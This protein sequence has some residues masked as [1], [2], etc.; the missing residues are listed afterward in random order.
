MI[1]LDLDERW[2]RNAAV[3]G[4]RVRR[5][6]PR[7]GPVRMVGIDGPSG[8]GKSEF[9]EA[10]VDSLR[11]RGETVALVPTDDFATWETPVGW[12]PRLEAGVLEPL[13]EGAPGSYRRMEWPDGRPALGG[14]VTV[15]VPTVLVVEGVSATRRAVASRLSLAIWVELTGAPTRLNRSVARDGAWSR[16]ALRRWQ[17]DEQRW[18][19]ADAPRDRADV[20]L[21]QP[22]DDGEIFGIEG[23]GRG[24]P[25]R[26]P[27]PLQ[28][29]T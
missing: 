16:T 8:S 1:P 13:S 11:G 3:V 2:R 19:A 23:E 14:R 15:D 25:G 21:L 20:L 10:L 28:F 18:F 7:L 6:E 5:V 27:E 26:G 22:G 12:W 4:E 17:R 29:P 24:F 9:A